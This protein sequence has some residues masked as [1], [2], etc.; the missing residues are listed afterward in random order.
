MR[1]IFFLPK[2]KR[3][4]KRMRSRGKNLVKLDQA[5]QLLSKTGTL[6]VNYQPHKLSGKYDDLWE[7][8]L[9]QDWLLVY[10][11]NEKEVIMHRTG[12]HADLFE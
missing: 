12:S 7:C 1:N 5:A 9:E 11:I 4:Y 10:D 6:P 2:I 8:H 3:D